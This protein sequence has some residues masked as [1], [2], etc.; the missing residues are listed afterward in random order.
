MKDIDFDELDKAVSGVLGTNKP[1]EPAV[2]TTVENKDDTVIITSRQ[3]T[4]AEAPQQPEPAFAAP[5]PTPAAATPLTSP[6]VRRGRFM[7]VVHPSSDMTSAGAPISPKAKTDIVAPSARKLAPISSDIV[8]EALPEP[9]PAE[10]EQSDDEPKL[11]TIDTPTAVEPEEP[12]AVEPPAPLIE[13]VPPIEMPPIASGENDETIA[14]E[15]EEK[16]EEPPLEHKEEPSVEAEDEF[17]DLTVEKVT[18][19]TEVTPTPFLTDTKVDKRPLGAFGAED[20]VAANEPLPQ[21]LN[22]EVL[23]VESKEATDEASLTTENVLSSPENRADDAQLKHMFDS[24]SYQTPL[25]ARKRSSAVWLWVILILIL[26]AVGSG[27]GYLW[28]VNGY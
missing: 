25:A 23:K 14:V 8:P 12:K 11:D 5:A 27:L 9:A 24:E 28:F 21:E 16:K 13:A 6:A 15:P 26:L 18:E 4:V 3:S 1:A 20:A 17:A 2:K 10:V 19:P 22:T 7:D